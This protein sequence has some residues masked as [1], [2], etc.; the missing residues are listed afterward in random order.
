MQVTAVLTN[1][2]GPAHKRTIA[3]RTIEE[4]MF[5]VP[6]LGSIGV[7]LSIFT[8]GNKVSIGT[9]HTSTQV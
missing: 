4:M 3:G 8:Y 6:G 9:T 5:W 2:P 7:V 1:V